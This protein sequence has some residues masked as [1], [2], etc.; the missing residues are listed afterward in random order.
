[1][2]SYRSSRRGERCFDVRLLILRCFKTRIFLSLLL[3]WRLFKSSTW[4]VN[5]YAERGSRSKIFSYVF[6]FFSLRS[7]H[8]L[9]LSLAFCGRRNKQTNP[10]LNR[11]SKT[12][13]RLDRASYDYARKVNYKRKTLHQK[14]VAKRHGLVGALLYIACL[15]DAEVLPHRLTVNR[16]RSI[17]KAQWKRKVS[18]AFNTLFQQTKNHEI[19]NNR[20]SIVLSHE[21]VIL[22]SIF[23]FRYFQLHHM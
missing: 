1:M 8:M 21:D 10:F 15:F 16:P 20:P 3:S 11:I 4:R 23:C 19:G 18:Y 5:Y 12:C 14:K 13:Y 6:I 22:N 7:L 2:A 9:L 17:P